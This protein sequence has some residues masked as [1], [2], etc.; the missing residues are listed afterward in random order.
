MNNKKIVKNLAI[1]LGIPIVV[2]F[3]I[4]F[5]F[6]KGFDNGP[7]LIYSDVLNYFETEQVKAYT[8]DLGTGEM[9]LTLE[10]ENKATDDDKKVGYLVPN[11]SLFYEA[12]SED[13]ENY[14]KLL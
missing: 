9:V 11:I 8:L 7:S 1:Y 3:I 10:G 5:M 2:L 13:I 14:N 6:G 4:F 12:V